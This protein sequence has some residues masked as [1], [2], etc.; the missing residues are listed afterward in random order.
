MGGALIKG[1]LKKGAISS[2]DILAYDL[3]REKLTAFCEETGASPA[4]DNESLV[5]GADT[6]ILAVKPQKAVDV[7]AGVSPV[8]SAEKLLISVVLGL[9]VQKL[10]DATGGRARYVRCMPNTPALVNAGMTCIAMGRNTCEADRHYTEC[11]FNAVGETE[12][13]SETDVERVTALTGSSPAYVF[14]MIE[15]MADAAV[16][17]GLPRD[18]SLRLAAQAVIGSAKMALKSDK[19]P[20]QLKDMVC[21]PAGSTIEAVRVLEEKGFRGALMAA[22]IACAGWKPKT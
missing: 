1:M 19:H 3:D 10:S 2:R 21:S 5:R 6:V 8:L 17:I 16:S 11:I 15:A 12:F 14:I 13:M 4:A 9:S 7:L 20:A 18:V 22:M